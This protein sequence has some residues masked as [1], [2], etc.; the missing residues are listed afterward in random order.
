MLAAIINRASVTGF[1]MKPANAAYKIHFVS[2]SHLN[3]GTENKKFRGSPKVRAMVDIPP[4]QQNLGTSDY[5]EYKTS[6]GFSRLF[7]DALSCL[8]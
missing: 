4:E 3:I 8:P 2:F 7:Q 5:T 6:I 1:L